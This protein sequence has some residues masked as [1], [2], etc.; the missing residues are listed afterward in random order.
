MTDGIS[1][2]IKIYNDKCPNF[3]LKNG[4]LSV[5]RNMPIVLSEYG[6]NYIVIDTTN[7]T[8]PDVLDSHSKSILILKDKI[9][10]NRYIV[11]VSICN[12]KLICSWVNSY[13]YWCSTYCNSSYDC[14]NISINNGYIVSAIVCNINIVF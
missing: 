3:E 7:N 13:A 1:K 10:Q 2:A 4:E 14:V 5:D 8:N 11:I 12:I 9:I 6:E